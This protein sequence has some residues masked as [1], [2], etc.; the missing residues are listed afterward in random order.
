MYM[1]ITS[2]IHK[3]KCFYTKKRAT[4]C[5]ATLLAER[6]GFEPLW[7]APNGFQDRLVM[8]TSIPLRMRLD[9][10]NTLDLQCQYLFLIILSF[11]K[12]LF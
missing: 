10:I 12:K 8:T 7:V 11:H 2:I 1:S 3:C 4:T 5:V 6:K 9:Y